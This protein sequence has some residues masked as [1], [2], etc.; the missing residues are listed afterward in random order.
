M[1]VQLF[2]LFAAWLYNTFI[3]VK[4]TPDLESFLIH[5]WALGDRLDAPRFKNAVIN[6]LHC[7]WSDFDLAKYPR[8]FEPA[9]LAYEVSTAGS[10]I[11]KLVIK[12]F[13]VH[14]NQAIAPPEDAASVSPELCL[15]LARAMSAIFGRLHE[16]DVDLDSLRDD[17]KDDELCA[18]Y[19]EH[20]DGERPCSQRKI[21]DSFDWG[22]IP[23]P[24]GCDKWLR[25]GTS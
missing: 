6:T 7:I 19:H 14:T 3:E 8:S 21:Y 5:A 11:R 10:K 12:K 18:T 2:E 13:S 20:H 16:R 23:E 4:R 25:L 1:N 15:D 17:L 9:A 22:D 24:D